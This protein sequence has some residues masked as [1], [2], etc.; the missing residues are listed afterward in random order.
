MSLSRNPCRRLMMPWSARLR[1]LMLFRSSSRA[2]I[3]HKPRIGSS[4]DPLP[5]LLLPL[6]A[7]IVLL[8]LRCGPQVR[9]QLLPGP[10]LPLTRHQGHS[11]KSG[12]A[13]LR[14][15]CRRGAIDP[16]CFIRFAPGSVHFGRNCCHGSP[17]YVLE[18]LR[19]RPA[20]IHRGPRQSAIWTKWA[21]DLPMLKPSSQS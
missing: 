2:M 19:C 10:K 16:R 8:P 13:T 4:A 1:E 11:R 15:R 14:K 9:H 17:P 6:K 5:S 21:D 12:I 7:C 20:L 3:A 18:G